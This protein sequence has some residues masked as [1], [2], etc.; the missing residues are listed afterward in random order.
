MSYVQRFYH[1]FKITAKEIADV[2]STECNVDP[3][4]V[5][6]KFSALQSGD[7]H[8]ISLF[9]NR[10]HK[11]YF[12]TAQCALLIA[13]IR[14]KESVPDHIPTLFLENAYQKF[15]QL[16]QHFSASRKTTS[17]HG[18]GEEKIHSTAKIGKNVKISSTAIISENVEIGDNTKIDTNA[19]IGYG[20]KIGEN[21][22]IGA[23]TVI[24][25]AVLGDNVK[26]ASNTN[27]GQK[28]FGFSTSA[29]GKHVRIPHIAYVCIGNEVEIG[30][31]TVVTRGFLVP[32]SI[33]EGTKIGNL[34]NI[35]HAVQIG[36]GCL[37]T[38]SIAIGGSTV[39]GD[40]CIIGGQVAISDHVIMGNHVT[41]S[42]RTGVMG[43]VADGTRVFG[44]LGE[45]YKQ[46]MKQEAF[47]KKLYQKSK[48]DHSNGSITK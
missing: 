26:I 46:Y 40:F 32:T 33:G 44:P 35:E 30:T 29:D 43:T 22:F 45:E 9:V 3:L 31:G 18:L 37:L 8:S 12:K 5:I 25:Y 38:G 1:S 21:S 6:E 14:L 28:G 23:N 20:C 16:I 48:A 7:K 2:L 11:R 19:V 24:Q 42:G 17:V 15:I 36:R 39:I 34:C 4:I 47:L 10:K 13:D 27:I 41:V